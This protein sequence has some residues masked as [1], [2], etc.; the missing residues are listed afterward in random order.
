MRRN[1]TLRIAVILIAFGMTACGGDDKKE[2]SGD[3]D[4]LAEVAG[5][6]AMAEEVAADLSVA[7]DVEPDLGE[8]AEPFSFATYNTG[9]AL[10]YV[11]YAAERYAAV[12]DALGTVEADVLCLQ[13]VWEVEH[14]DGVIAGLAEAY[15]H[16][17]YADTTVEDTGTPPACTDE[18]TA[19]L[20]ACVEENC[21]EAED[22]TG[23]VM[24]KCAAQ[25]AQVSN[26]CITC[27]AA[28]LTKPIDEI[29]ATCVLGGGSLS[30]EGRN[31]LIL[32][33]K[34]E[35]DVTDHLVLDSFLVQRAVLYAT[36]KDDPT[37]THAFC[38]HLAT[39]T[40]APYNGNFEGYK[41]EQAA[42]IAAMLTFV[43]D[44][45]GD[46]AVVL[47]GDMN[48]APAIG[49]DL[50]AEWEENFDLFG[51]ADLVAPFVENADPVCTWCTAN[52]LVGEGSTNRIIDHVFLRNVDQV[53][54]KAE[55]ILDQLVSV[56]VEGAPMEM[57]LS[58]H[59]GVWV[60]N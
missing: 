17:F 30:Y 53:Y 1:W 13:E 39:S 55:R 18:E 22:L 47:M 43:D 23:C 38:T 26:D 12:L 50:A 34:R 10:N 14:V 5:T 16:A 20:L 40:E 48:T 15:P 54:L 44:K 8:P 37:G 28:N 4:V 36:F 32:L 29:F 11:D 35:L 56:G 9:L 49:A 41:E 52:T 6:D 3:P 33:S 46:G 19:P 27:L 7:E 42:Q 57:N 2:E 60:H 24:D 31:G 45:A 58:D 51:A 21:L 25:F 59:F